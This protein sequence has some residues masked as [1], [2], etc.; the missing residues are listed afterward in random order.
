MGELT[1]RGLVEAARWCGEQLTGLPE[2]TSGTTCEARGSK[3]LEARA[4]WK[5]EVGRMGE[6]HALLG[7]ME[8]RRGR[9]SALLPD[10][11]RERGAGQRRGALLVKAEGWLGFQVGSGRTGTPAER[12]SRDQN[13]SSGLWETGKGG[14]TADGRGELSAVLDSVETGGNMARKIPGR[15]RGHDRHIRR[16]DDVDARRR[17]QR[18]GRDCCFCASRLP[19][20][21][22]RRIPAGKGLL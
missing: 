17:V 7:R 8:D 1:S 14:G 9:E 2:E 21:R 20:G 13:G 15:P 19:G 6:R 5:Q 16:V 18:P 3:E 12:M 22:Q 4:M 10:R 11:L